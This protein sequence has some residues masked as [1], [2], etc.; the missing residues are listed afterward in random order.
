M[1]RLGYALARRAPVVLFIDD[2]QWADAASLDVLQYASRRWATA[3]LPVFLLCTFRSEDLASSVA[4]ADWL[5]GL[6]RN[7]QIRRQTLNSLTFEDTMRLVGSLFV[8]GSGT[9][10]NGSEGQAE[11]DGR[12]EAL[13][14]W[15]FA[16]TRGHPFFLIE[17]FKLFAEQPG[18]L[19]DEAGAVMITPDLSMHQ[20]AAPFTLPSRVRDLIHERLT[21]LGQ[22][23]LTLCVAAAVLGDGFNFEQLCRVAD[24]EENQ[25]L[26][27][28]DE[29]LTRGLLRETGGRCFF[30]HDSI[31]GGVYAEASET[32]RRVFHRRALET[33]QAAL[34]SPAKL[35]HHAMAS[36]LPDTAARL[37]IAA[38]DAVAQYEQAR[39]PV[40]QSNQYLQPAMKE[41]MLVSQAD[42]SQLYPQLGSAYE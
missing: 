3:H 27:A 12:I 9:I 19:R 33:L 18:L 11:K 31:R 35:A 38:G 16:Q 5:T 22:S 1:A 13:S 41:N 36:G 4:L 40:R 8:A 14:R 28:L 42:M 29:L 34:A 17:H 24:I 10:E 23:A 2:A 6:E 26:P 25:A 7:L 20:E 15:L 37:S 21:R 30:A 39:Q 32:R